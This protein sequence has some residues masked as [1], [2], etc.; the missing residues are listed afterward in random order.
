MALIDEHC[1][2]IPAGTPPLTAAEAAT[3]AAQVPEWSVGMALLR[4]WTFPDFAAAM[5]FANQVADLAQAEDHHP[6]LCISYG[7]ITVALATHKI[8]GLSRN[9]FILAAKIDAL[10]YTATG[11]SSDA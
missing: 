3:L 8:G 7:K 5:A 4:G 11:A 9:D 2:P 1:R 6:D 10:G